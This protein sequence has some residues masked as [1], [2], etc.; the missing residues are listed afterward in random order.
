M[1]LFAC[2]AALAAR[3]MCAQADISGAWILQAV[4]NQCPGSQLVQSAGDFIARSR[5]SFVGVNSGGAGA[6]HR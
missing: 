6:L 1:K 4:P 3:A 5:T 2:L